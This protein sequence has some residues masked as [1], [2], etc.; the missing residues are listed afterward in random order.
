VYIH[1]HAH[2]HARIHTQRERQTDRHT[3]T[4]THRHT[5]LYVLF[6]CLLSLLLLPEPDTHFQK[7]VPLV[8]LQQ[9]VTKERTFENAHFSVFALYWVEMT[10]RQILGEKVVD[11]KRKGNIHSNVRVR[12]IL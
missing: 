2:K 6:F 4:H 11:Y 8:L 9:K 5:H 3:D 12:Q 10:T 7:S 1:T